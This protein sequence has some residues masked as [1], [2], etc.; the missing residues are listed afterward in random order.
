M[1]LNICLLSAL[2]LA[3]L[4]LFF[5]AFPL[6]FMNNHGFNLWQTGLTFCGIGLGMCI[7]IASDPL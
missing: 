7:A 6:V 4:Y 1:C 2:L 3:I 5:G